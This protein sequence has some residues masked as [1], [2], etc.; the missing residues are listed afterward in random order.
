MTSNFKGSG[1]PPPSANGM[2][3]SRFKKTEYAL[4]EAIA[5]GKTKKVNPFMLK[6]GE[7]DVR[8]IT[9]DR[10]E[11]DTSVRLHTRFKANGNFSN[12]VVC[13]AQLDDRGCPLCDVLEEQAKWFAC[14]SVLDGNKW[15][16]PSGPRK[17]QV[18][19]LQRRLLLVNA[20]Q[21]DTFKKLG[22]KVGGWHGQ[23]FDVSRSNDEKSAR[24]GTQWFPISKATDA[25]LLEKVKGIAEAY[26]LTPEQYIEPFNYEK[27]L[28]PLSHEKLTQI[29]NAI[30]AGNVAPGASVPA[31]EENEDS[32]PF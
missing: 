25:Q 14:G 19:T 24:I 9:L 4:Y 29:A 32:V 27:V 5:G 20:R 8:V 30:K 31:E 7:E 1:G 21:L 6:A 23:E 2:G 17:G 15:E 10:G 3:G 13:I 26:G 22:S 12:H 28:E 11:F 18:I 16:I